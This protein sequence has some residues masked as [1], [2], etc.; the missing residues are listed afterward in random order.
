MDTATMR[1]GLRMCSNVVPAARAFTL[2]E[3]LV[4]IAIIAILIAILLPALASVRRTGRHAVCQAN[5]Q[6]TG[7]GHHAYATDFKDY[8]AAYN[9]R[10]EELVLQNPAHAKIFPTPNDCA[11]QALEIVQTRDPDASM[12]TQFATPGNNSPVINEQHSHLVLADYLAS[13]NVVMPVAVCPE[14]RARI[15][16]QH[17]VHSMDPNQFTHSWNKD[18]ASWFPYSSSYQLFPAGWTQDR[19]AGTVGQAFGQEQLAYHNWYKYQLKPEPLGRRKITE[20]LLPSQKVAVADTQQR[21]FGTEMYFLYAEA[22][23]PVLMWDGAVL[24]K[25]T[26]DSNRGWDRRNHRETTTTRLSYFPD[27]AFESPVV[28]RLGGIVKAGYYKW[29]RG[30]LQGADFSGGEPDTSNW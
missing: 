12:L 27:P 29:T 1:R 18:N 30:G 11:K 19:P 17:Q 7:R 6:Q 20:V 16:F 3:L 4:V 26:S 13:G 21:H 8:I 15:G 2:I 5:L 22:R 28:Q 9:G 25:R 24:T 14:D 23:Q 10:L